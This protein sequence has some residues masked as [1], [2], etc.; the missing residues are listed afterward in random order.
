MT[1]KTIRINALSIYGYQKAIQE[2]NE[3]KKWLN[4]KAHELQNRIA[5]IIVNQAQPIFDSAVADDLI[6]MG[7]RTGNVQVSY[8]DRGKITVVIADGKDAIFMEFGAGVYHNGAVGTSPNPWGADFGFTIGSYGE[9]GKRNVWGYKGPDGEIYL[10]HGVPAS[11]PLYN[12][13]Q[14]VLHN[15]NA[16]AK[17]VFNS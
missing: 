14:S 13:V 12:A 10:T 8:D 16:I 11:M 2:L 7:A 9:N 1:K 5:E 15:L 3:Y 17:E 4:D 6:S